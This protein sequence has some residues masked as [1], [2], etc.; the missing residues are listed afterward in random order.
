MFSVLRHKDPATGSKAKVLA[1]QIE[2]VTASGPNEV[3]FRL[4]SPNADLPV[5]QL[6]DY[7]NTQFQN[8]TR[9]TFFAAS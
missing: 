3:T 6:W 7:V 8:T 2:E 4:A 5:I 1:D 9:F